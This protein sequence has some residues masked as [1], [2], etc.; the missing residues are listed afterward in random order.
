MQ[1]GTIRIAGAGISGLTAA[2]NLASQGNPVEVFEKNE[3]TGNNRSQDLDAIDNWSSDTDFRHLLDRWGV[4]P[5]FEIYPGESIEIYDERSLLARVVSNR[6]LFYLVKRGAVQGSLDQALKKQANLA[7]VRIRY[8]ESAQ[9]EQVDIWA[10]GSDH[11]G[12]FLNVGLTFQTQAPDTFAFLYSNR[13]APR[14]YAYLAIISGFGKISV[15]LMDDFQNAQ[16][17]LNHAIETFQAIKH[18]DLEDSRITSGF[19]G[20]TRPLAE[21]RTHPVRVGE[22]A[23]FQDFM[24]GFGIRHA[25]QS[26]YL[27]AAAIHQHQ[28]FA[29]LSER[30]IRPQVQASAV[31]RLIYDSFPGTVTRRFF[32]AL[33]DTPNLSA[34]L[35][36]APVAPVLLPIL[37]PLA[38]RHLIRQISRDD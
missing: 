19:V 22:A 6:P 20:D 7:G 1:N 4:E 9:P 15:L 16:V 25:F 33:P 12:V 29:T 35:R 30:E 23:G 28:D 27:A 2:V 32:R 14:A 34:L 26:G 21:S 11:T 8:R 3:D 17:H 18:F 24:W 31:R 10:A 38:R 37:W 36:R 13:A 5:S